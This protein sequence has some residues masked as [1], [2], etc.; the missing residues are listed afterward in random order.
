MPLAP[1]SQGFPLGRFGSE[2]NLAEGLELIRLSL[3]RACVASGQE[4]AGQTSLHDCRGV[5]ESL[6]GERKLGE[7]E[8]RA[9]EG[10]SIAGQR[11]DALWMFNLGRPAS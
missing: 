8:Q 3:L 7:H 1:R 6:S 9:L 4:T 11:P 2:A 10:Y 5:F